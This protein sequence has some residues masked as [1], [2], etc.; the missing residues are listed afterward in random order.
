MRSASFTSRL[1]NC[2][3]KSIVKVDVIIVFHYLLVIIG[4]IQGFSQ[5]EDKSYLR[6]KVFKW[7][8]PI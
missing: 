4:F 6:F 8:D 1:A 5:V 2:V 7:F 3:S